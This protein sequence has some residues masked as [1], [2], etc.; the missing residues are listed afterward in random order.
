MEFVITQNV[1]ISYTANYNFKLVVTETYQGITSNSACLW[2]VTVKCTRS[3]SLVNNPIL[4]SM[5]YILDP[6][7]LN[8]S[9]LTLPTYS[10]SPAWC[11]AS[12][13]YAITETSTTLCPPWIT[14]NPTTNSNISISTSDCTAEG[15]HSLLLTLKDNIS[16]LTNT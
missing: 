10:P 7:N 6:N 9:T 16:M 12:F 14:C 11:T 3:L 4:A 13:S 15:T 5:T 8:I 1:A 2:T